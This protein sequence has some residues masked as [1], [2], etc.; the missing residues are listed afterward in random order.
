[1]VKNTA[2]DN[3][4]PKDFHAFIMHTPHSFLPGKKS[5]PPSGRPV[6]KAINSYLFSW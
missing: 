1:M 5:A 2:A 4:I 3:R 6:V